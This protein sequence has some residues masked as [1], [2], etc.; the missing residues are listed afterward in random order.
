MLFSLAELLAGSGARVTKDN[1]SVSGINADSRAIGAGEAFFALPGTKAHGDSFAAD[2]VARGA[3]AIISDRKLKL[4]AAVPV[5]VVRDVRAAYARAA[6]RRYAPQPRTS[7]A[8]TGTNGKTSVASFVRQIWEASG[9]RSASLGTLGIETAK[10]LAAGSLT[11][12]DPLSLHREL[13]SL[14]KEGITN[15]ALEASSHGLEQRRLDGMR[16]AAVGFTN[17]TRD[18]L[19]YHQSMAAYADAKLR[20]FRELAAEH[21]AAVINTDDPECPP[22]VFAAPRQWPPSADG[23]PR[24]RVLRDPRHRQ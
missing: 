2:A 7:V 18:H 11:T 19:D 22:F 23:G 20:L 16:F 10:G 14:R 5:L 3:V 8:V 21:G 6:A 9:F 24:G 12:P 13:W 4:D 17:L 15:V 1:L